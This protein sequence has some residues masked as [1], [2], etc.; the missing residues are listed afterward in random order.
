MARQI[1]YCGKKKKKSRN[2]LSDFSHSTS[3]DDVKH[4][5]RVLKEKAYQ[6]PTSVTETGKMVNI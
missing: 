4:G 3:S 2:L 1:Y 6:G 5:L